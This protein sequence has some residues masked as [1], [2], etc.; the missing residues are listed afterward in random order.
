MTFHALQTPE[1]R[2]LFLQANQSRAHRGKH[3]RAHGENRMTT[4]VR[5]VD[6]EGFEPSTLGLREPAS[7]LGLSRCIWV[8][9]TNHALDT[10]SVSAYLGLSRWHFTGTREGVQ[11]HPDWN[12]RTQVLKTPLGLEPTISS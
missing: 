7:H 1:T 12:R 2:L 6:R 4:T 5:E 8:L 3:V 10:S 9:Q 11:R